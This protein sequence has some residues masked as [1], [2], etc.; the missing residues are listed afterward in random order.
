MVAKVIFFI[1]TWR[2]LI[3]KKKISKKSLFKT[4]FI[5]TFF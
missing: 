3:I 1:T 2:C 5:K 4:Y